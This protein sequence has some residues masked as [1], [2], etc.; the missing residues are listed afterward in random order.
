MSASEI[1]TYS[2]DPKGYY[3]VLGINYDAS[4]EEI[5]LHY[6][7]K[8]KQWHPDHN[9]SEEALE[10]FQKISVAY[11]IL[12]DEK[13]RLSYDLLAQVY[14]R[15]K[16]PDMAA[17][18]AY[19]NQKGVED[20]FLRAVSLKEVVGMLFKCRCEERQEICNFKE[21][22][23]AVFK[24]SL[25]NFM[26]GWWSP[27]SF[28]KNFSALID[29]YKNINR[30]PQEN[31]TLLVHNAL[32]YGQENKPELAYLSAVQA[33][34][35]ANLYQKGLLHRFV[36]SLGVSPQIKIPVW[37]FG[38]LKHLQLV[39]PGSVV[40]LL[41]LSMTSTVM[42]SAEFNK[43]FGDGSS[44]NYYQEVQFSSGG[45]TVDDVVVSKILN[46][47]VNTG[48]LNKL[49]HVTGAVKVM[50][51][52]D[53][54]FDVLAKLKSRTTVRITGYTPDKKWYRVMLDNGDMGF[55]PAST[56]KKGIG[57]EI[58]EG[59]KIYTGIKVK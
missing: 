24:T 20:A 56:L 28:L 25:L 48:D 2:T 4:D 44:I 37:N 17:L 52:P 23:K 40:F 50:Y 31:L 26:L 29:N 19:K 53:E 49:Y 27:Q 18:K 15:E 51:G 32:A 5:K 8:A 46:I 47:P 35:Y 9:T 43:R 57:H 12:K 13:N 22:Q 41:A 30:N 42:T 58:P 1:K 14:S 7:E 39:I 3:A 16:F 21:A 10:N 45:T 11:D 38:L 54:D 59:S 36:A 33:L 6:R 34:D 55:V